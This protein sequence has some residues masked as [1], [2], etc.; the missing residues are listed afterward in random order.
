MNKIFNINSKDNDY[1]HF[2]SL[3]NSRQKRNKNKENRTFRFGYCG[4]SLREP[5]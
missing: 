2:L 4:S 1:L 5:G 3:K